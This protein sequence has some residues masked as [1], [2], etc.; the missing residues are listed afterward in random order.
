MVL[1]G[2]ISPVSLPDQLAFY[3]S[4]FISSRRTDTLSSNRKNG[5]QTKAVHGLQA[6]SFI[7]THPNPT[8]HI[9]VYSTNLLALFFV[10]TSIFDVP[11]RF[12]VSKQNWNRTQ[13]PTQD[14]LFTRPKSHLC[15]PTRPI[16]VVSSVFLES[17]CHYA[18]FLIY[19][20]S[21]V[22][23]THRTIDFQLV[24]LLCNDCCCSAVKAPSERACFF[25]YFSRPMLTS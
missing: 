24:V 8:G 17:T 5:F 10:F 6:V 2:V 7:F 19:H 9:C 18:I 25:W 23:V 15:L 14:N 13:S 1:R 16:W 22:S 21:G 3:V 20:T 11:T 4:V 12:Q